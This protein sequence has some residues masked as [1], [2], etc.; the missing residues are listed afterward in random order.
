MLQI[1]LVKN[2]SGRFR[3]GGKSKICWVIGALG[4]FCRPNQYYNQLSVRLPTT[5]RWTL[6]FIPP[7]TGFV[8][9]SDLFP[10][11]FPFTI[12]RPRSS[13]HGILT[14]RLATSRLQEAPG[15]LLT[16]NLDNQ[17]DTHGHH[18][19]F[20]NCNH[21]CNHHTQKEPNKS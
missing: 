6:C 12:K 7:M 3:E 19:F 11:S 5:R 4:K 18:I 20:L 13:S 16:Y 2:F 15:F 8:F 9:L 14:N 17:F 1:Q 10:L 21:F